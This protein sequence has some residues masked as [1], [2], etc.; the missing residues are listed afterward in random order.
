MLWSDEPFVKFVLLMLYIVLVAF[1]C[2]HEE[3]LCV[4]YLEVEKLQLIDE[5]YEA[6]RQKGN[7]WAS[8]EAKLT[9][10]RKE[11]EEHAQA[12]LKAKVLHLSFGLMPQNTF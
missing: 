2:P 7:R 1:K 5:E 6:L 8:V 12:E 9:E 4:D 11:M 3:T 10:Y